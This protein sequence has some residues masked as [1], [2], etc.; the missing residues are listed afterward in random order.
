[1]FRE[2]KQSAIAKF[3]IL[4]AL[5]RLPPFGKFVAEEAAVHRCFSK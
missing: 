4:K 1:M 2:K 5:K 3:R